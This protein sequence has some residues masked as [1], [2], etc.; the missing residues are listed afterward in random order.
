MGEYI[1]VPLRVPERVQQDGK[2]YIG[3]Y[4]SFCCEKIYEDLLDIGGL[5][6]DI[7]VLIDADNKKHFSISMSVYLR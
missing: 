7:D 3:V 2:Y 5:C 4:L 1:L 6:V